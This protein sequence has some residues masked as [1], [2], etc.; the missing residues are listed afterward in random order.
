MPAFEFKAM[1]PGGEE[2]AG[3]IEAANAEEAMHS[4]RA[5]G[6]FVTK[7]GEVGEGPDSGTSSLS[8]DKSAKASPA[9]LWVLFA[10]G[11]ASLLFGI[12]MF[13]RELQF[14]AGAKEV[15]GMKVQDAVRQR[16]VLQVRD[17]QRVVEFPADPEDNRPLGPVTLL[18]NSELSAVKYRHESEDGLLGG[19]FFAAL[20]SFFLLA[21]LVG[22]RNARAGTPAA[23][24]TDL[25]MILAGVAAL[26]VVGCWIVAWLETGRRWG[27]S[28]LLFL[29]L[30]LGLAVAGL[31][32]VRHG[33]RSLLGRRR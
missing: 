16:T 18:Y 29:L 11:L 10:A 9:L 2:E 27:F 7:L 13:G 14:R 4:L 30:M 20:G 15:T 5:R 6:L 24:W 1:G 12:G 8:L 22:L 31:A 32:A 26:G 21:A 28:T 19:P 33:S 23:R 25:A 17:G 3:E